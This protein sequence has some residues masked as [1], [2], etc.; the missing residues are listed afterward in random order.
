MFSCQSSKA[1]RERRR[2]FATAYSKTAV[3]QP[4]VRNLIKQRMA[5]LLQYLDQQASLDFATSKTSG[6][7]VVRQVFRALQADIFTAFVFSDTEGTTFLDKL[8]EGPDMMEEI[9]MRVIHLGHEDRRDAYFFWESEKPFKHIQYL[10]NR[11]G[12]SAHKKAES[13]LKELAR[14]YESIL[15]IEVTTEFADQKLRRLEQSPYKKICLWKDSVTGKGLTFTERT[16]EILD[17]IIAGQDPVPAALEFIVKQLSIQEDIQSRLRAELLGSMDVLA[18]GYSTAFVD[19]LAYLDCIVMESLRL[20]DNIS[21][22]QTRIVP[23]GGCLILG[24]FLPGG[25][26]N[27][28]LPVFFATSFSSNDINVGTTT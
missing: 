28:P 14:K 17:H 20:V 16:S 26:S 18:K 12:I 5:K 7:V 3:S 11:S 25:V 10:Y 23:A 24:C 6:P 27:S 1:H 13:W 2:I 8:G 21:S 22:Y 15:S 19:S 9:V 4:A